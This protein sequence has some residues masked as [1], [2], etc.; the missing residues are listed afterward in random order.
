[1]A[2]NPDSTYL[3]Q[4]VKWFSWAKVESKSMV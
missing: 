4:K 3:S 2:Q 1:M